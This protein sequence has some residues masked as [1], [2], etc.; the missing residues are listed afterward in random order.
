MGK[1]GADLMGAAGFQ[2]HLHQRKL[3]PAIQRLIGGDGGFAA[4]NRLIPHGDLLFLLILHQKDLD[5]ALG[6][7]G[8]AHGDAQIP[9]V[10][11]TVP[12][13][14]IDDPQRLGVFGGDDDAAGVAVNTVAQGGGEGVFPLGI[15]LPLLVQVCLNVVDEGVDLLRL[16]GVYHQPRPLVQQQQVFVLVHDGETGL[17]QCQKQVILSGLVEELVVDV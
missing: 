12:D 1:G 6:R 10:D 2:P 5:P 7:P 14:L 8:R 11:L 13:L 16:V 4:G 15:P 17:E 3:A 9:L